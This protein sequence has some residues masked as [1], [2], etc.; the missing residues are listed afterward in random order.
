MRTVV[1]PSA[2]EMNALV[3]SIPARRV[4]QFTSNAFFF[5]NSG[6]N[7]VVQIQMLPLLYPIETLPLKLCNLPEPFLAHPVPQPIGHVFHNSV[8]VMHHCRADLHVAA[9][10]QQ[11][12]RRVAPI[13]NA[14][15]SAEWQTRL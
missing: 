10:Q 4:T 3:R 13:R 9:S 2:I 11:K 7:L 1:A 8:S 6:H 15:D 5:M 12:F 14:A